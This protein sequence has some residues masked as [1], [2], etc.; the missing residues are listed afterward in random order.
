[1][2]YRDSFVDNNGK[3]CFVNGHRQVFEEIKEERKPYQDDEYEE[4]DYC[5][6]S[7]DECNCG[8]K[9]KRMIEVD[10]VLGVGSGE[11]T[12]EVCIP[13]CPPAVEV[14]D[15]LA[16]E[17]VVFDVL[18][19]KDGK[20]FINGRLLKNIPYKA[21]CGTIHP[22][23][24]SISN[25]AT[26]DARSAIAEIPFVICADVPGAVKGGKVVVLDYD[27][28]SLNLPNH[29]SCIPGRCTAFCE[30]P[31]SRFS[32]CGCLIRSITEKDCISVKVKVVK[33]EIITLPHHSC[34]DY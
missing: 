26:C 12:V 20:V 25:L 6:G 8:K 4:C 31:V 23:C 27:V 29:T 9:H 10:R 30:S 19:A 32:S 11:T 1:M 18:V 15:C 28:N 16:V 17:K 7:E 5:E 33:P 34:C 21:R 2:Y 24:R 13:L 14:M 22:G 3:K